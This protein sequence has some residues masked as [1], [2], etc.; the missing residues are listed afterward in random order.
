MKKQIICLLLFLSWNVLHA[1][2]EVAQK[3]LTINQSQETIT[4][5]CEKIL[6]SKCL[7]EAKVSIK[8]V[9]LKNSETVFEKN[10]HLPLIPASN[11]KIITSV[12]ALHLLK[13]EYTFKISFYH[14]GKIENGILKGN[15]YLKGYGAP[16]L[17]GEMIWIMLK[18]FTQSGIIR[19]EG[20]LVGD[21]S[22]FDHLE[23]PLSWPASIGDDPY[24]APISALACN[25]SSVKVVVKP[26][27]LNE[28]PLVHLS[29]FSDYFKVI[30]KAKTKGTKR[31]LSLKRV[32]TNGENKIVI[33]GTIPPNASEYSDYRSVENPTLYTLF[34]VREILRSL[35]V[36][37]SGA[38]KR[39]EVP[40]SAKEIFTFH[41]R[42]LSKIIYDM[43]KHSNNFMAEMVLKSLG[44]E[45]IGP[46]GTTEKGTEVLKLFMSNAIGAHSNMNI[47][48]GSGLSKKNLL[49]ADS[50]VR[51]L[52]FMNRQ[53]SEG[54][55]F[56]TSLPIGGADGTLKNR[57]TDEVMIRE[58]RGKTGYLNGVST[59]SG[60]MKNKNGERLGF[61]ILINHSKCHIH[62]TQNII[63]ELCKVISQS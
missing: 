27:P 7:R 12:A 57:F 51:V 44:A 28:K 38:I 6:S 34:S 25:F 13:P 9:S 49:S 10:S 18:E 42:P 41:L 31:S 4:S 35:D 8:V 46:P 47:S 37:I 61:S 54:Y 55:E 16:D 45:I 52:Q 14:D 17:V 29:P 11:M 63:D 53:F 50:I 22:Y 32:Y 33:S 20:D 5:R 58:V 56:I 48:D 1:S 23:R 24:S 21:D 39:G 43:N 26:G 19:V 3:P 60:Y 62:D 15:L 36:K 30:N 59:L 40:S 2:S